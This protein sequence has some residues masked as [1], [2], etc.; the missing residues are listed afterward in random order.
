M[1]ALVIAISLLDAVP[2]TAQSTAWLPA[3]EA[4]ERIQ[5]QGKLS[6]AE[7]NLRRL[8]VDE[9]LPPQGRAR[10][11]NDIGSICQDQFRMT[12]ANRY[13]HLAL[14]DWEKAGPAHRIALSRTLNNLA[15]LLWDT[16]KLA[17]SEQVLLRSA[18]LQIE[19]VGAN[20]PLAAPLFYN[21][22]ALHFRRHLWEQ[23][24][25][26][27]R[28]FLALHSTNAEPILAAVANSNLALIC[29]RTKREQ[30]AA[31]LFSSATS[32]Y[33]QLRN[34][35]GI[36]PMHL[37]DLAS[38]LHGGNRDDVASEVGRAALAAVEGK[39]GP[40][41]PKTAQAMTV[42]AAILRR[43]N[44]K[45]EARQLERQANEIH[46]NAAHMRASMQSVDMRELKMPGPLAS[47]ATQAR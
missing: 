11:Y 32:I 23:A 29:R 7:R 24:E 25:R 47:A 44:R 8:L 41:H 9:S 3:V 5:A 37:V 19:V 36:T 16:G 35:A 4:A 33:N 6:E 21:L 34:T 22:G 40:S 12:D 31:A 14:E 20:H 26:A 13:Y 2:A 45:A 43:N 42:Y 18:S 39:F 1:K 46:G 10:I 15:S 38:S 27:Y 17:E 28:D 30:E